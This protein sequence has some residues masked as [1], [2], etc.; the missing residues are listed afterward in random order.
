MV[1]R[2]A[3]FTW[4]VQR[5][6][7]RARATFLFIRRGGIPHITLGCYPGQAMHQHRAGP[8]P[9]GNYRHDRSRHTQHTTKKTSKQKTQNDLKLQFIIRRHFA[10][11][12]RAFAAGEFVEGGVDEAWFVAGE[13]RVADVDIFVDHHLARHVLQRDQ[14]ERSRA[15]DRA[16]DGID[17]RQPPVRAQDPGDAGIDLFLVLRHAAHEACEELGIGFA[18]GAG[19]R[20]AA[21]A[22]FD[23]FAHDLLGV[24]ARQLHLIERLHGGKP[25]RAARLAVAHRLMP[26]RAR[27]ST[28]AR[29][30]RAATP[31]L[32]PP[33]RAAR[34]SAW[35]SF[36]TVR[37]PLPIQRPWVSPRSIS[38]RALSPATISKRKVSPRITQP[39]A[40]K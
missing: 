11:L 1:V 24:D 17:T 36:S 9:Q 30:A 34:I 21:E 40:T 15:Q 16:Q 8:G 27:A 37:M 13:E 2:A 19:L 31:P 7:V 6:I 38:P 4:S 26:N 35:P 39:S 20:L 12:H 10:E 22:V 29:Q 14:F 25:R 33:S 3:T 32:S 5:S 28:S 23:E 18:G